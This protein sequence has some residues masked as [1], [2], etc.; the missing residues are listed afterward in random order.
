MAS[1]MVIH[2][3][4][5]M[6]LSD[7]TWTLDEGAHLGDTFL[8]E[9]LKQIQE[10]LWVDSGLSGWDSEDEESMNVCTESVSSGGTCKKS[11]R[12][13][14]QD[15]ACMDPKDWRAD[16]IS[17]LER[18]EVAAAI[19]EYRDVFSSVPDDT[20]QTNMVP[21]S[22]ET[23]DHR[24]IFLPPRWLPITKQDVEKAE[25][26][27]MLDEG[28][29]QQG[30]TSWSWATRVVLVTNKDGLA[31]FCMDYHKVNKATHKDA[32]ALPWIDETLDETLNTSA[33]WIYTQGTGK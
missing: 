28:V 23:G 31:R 29:I 22:I 20:G 6:N 5:M 8:V 24:P 15:D 21:H 27:K 12:I 3:I 4:P 16:N 33:P 1:N 25:V 32:Y 2:D 11:H 13:N 26:Q 30:Q 19:Y 7:A 14:T 10:M 9:M 18:E 17:M